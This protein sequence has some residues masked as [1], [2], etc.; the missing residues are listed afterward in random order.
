MKKHTL[1]IFTMLMLAAACKQDKPVEK[2]GNLVAVAPDDDLA[3][4]VRK[5]TLVV[6]TPQQYEWQ[7]LEY[8]AFLH[9]GPNSFTGVEWG[10]GM[11]DPTVF[12][13]TEF[14]AEQW[15]SVIKGA[16]MKLAMLTAKHHDGFCLWPTTTTVHSVK[17]L[18][19]E[20]RQRRCAGRF[21][22]GSQKGRN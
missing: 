15:I 3:E 17:K 8:I 12:N 11:E 16:G 13:P 18:P 7:K 21:G 6:P 2:L 19:L 22:E 10:S 5:S 1:F 14:D 20:R 4:I 9:F